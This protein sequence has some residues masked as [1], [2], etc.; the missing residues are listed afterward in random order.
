[1]LFLHERV[2]SLRWVGVV[3]IMA[4]AALISYSQHQKDKEQA[5]ALSSITAGTEKSQ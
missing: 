3:L 4:G 1:M 2:S 5:A